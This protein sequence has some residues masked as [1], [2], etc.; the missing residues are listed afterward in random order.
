MYRLPPHL[1]VLAPVT[2]GTSYYAVTHWLPDDRPLLAAVAR[3][4]PAGLLL[5][6]LAPRLPSGRWLWRLTVLGALNIGIFF[7]LLFVGAERLPGG[8]AAT[9][10]ALQPL[11][12]AGL[13]ARLLGQSPSLRVLAAGVAGVVGVAMLVLHPNAGL[14]TVGLLA[15][16]GG[17]VSMALGVV[18]TK[19]W[20]RPP[21]YGF[22]AFTGWQLLTGSAL[23]VPVLLAVEG[24]PRSLSAENVGGIAYLTLVGTAG[25]YTLWF[26]S[27]GRLPVTAVSLMG[28]MSPV[29]AVSIGAAFA[30]ETLNALQVAGIVVVL[31]A[32]FMGQGRPGRARQAQHPRGREVVPATTVASVANTR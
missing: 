20:G 26:W 17:A 31:A 16:L 13:G 14:D 6:L 12:V 24:L 30:G 9:V 5:V 7:A 3:A 2:W 1:G 8:V 10:G 25:A 21:G 22:A 27:I 32:V 19:H 29:V 23:L 28:L 18:L 15:A 11:I 4:L